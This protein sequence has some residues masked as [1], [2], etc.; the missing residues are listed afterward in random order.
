MLPVRELRREGTLAQAQHLRTELIVGLALVLLLNCSWIVAVLIVVPW[1][2]LAG[3]AG[4]SG[5]V[6]KEISL[7]G[8][9]APVLR[10]QFNHAAG[11]FGIV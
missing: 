6:V 10:C 11:Q 9:A 5:L 3:L 7:P 2:A 1:L 8:G 4:L